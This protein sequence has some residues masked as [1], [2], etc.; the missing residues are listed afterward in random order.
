MVEFTTVLD[1]KDFLAEE[2]DE[3]FWGIYTKEGT[4]IGYASLC[5]FQ[6]KGRCEFSIFILDKR[7]W[8]RGIGREVTEL[9]LEYAFN[10]LDMRMIVLETSEFN[11]SAIRLYKRM[12][13][14]ITQV[15]PS[16]RTIWHEG[17]WVLSGSVIMQKK[18]ENFLSIG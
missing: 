2:E 14:Q 16:D 7:Y 8:G 11:E 3:I 18:R 5:G 9:M 1:V 4:C 6:G 13:F 17:A 15:I 10:V 12:G